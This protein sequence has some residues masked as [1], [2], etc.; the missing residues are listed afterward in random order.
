ML[1]TLPI[2]ADQT[3][4][5]P[6]PAV[7]VFQSMA[8]LTFAGLFVVP[9]AIFLFQRIAYLLRRKKRSRRLVENRVSSK[10]VVFVPCYREKSGI[11][12]R[13]VDSLVDSY[14]P[15]SSLQVFL[16]FD[17]ASEDNL[18]LDALEKLGMPLARR[19]GF[20]SSVDIVYKRVRVTVS[21][22]THGGKRCCQRN[23]FKLV[24]KVY[25]DYLRARG[26]IFALFV[27][28]D[29][30][31]DRH[32]IR[33]LVLEMELKSGTEGVCLA[34]TGVVTATAEKNSLITILQD[35]EY[36]HGQ[37]FERAIESACGA[38]TCLPGALT[39]IRFSTLN[40]LA[41]FYFAEKSAKCKDLF[42]YC[43]CH[44]GEDRWFTHLLMIAAPQRHQL[45]ICTSAFC[46]TESAQSFS[47][48]LKQRRRWFLGFLTNEVCI[49]SDRRLWR[50]YSLLCAIHLAQDTI[51]TTSL[52]FFVAM[53]SVL[54]GTRHYDPIITS[55]IALSFG[56]HWALM[57]S[58]AWNL[59][60]YK[61]LLFPV[62]F[63]VSQSH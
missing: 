6:K 4:N 7:I 35:L 29:C 33:N 32:C 34:M 21:R 18:Y 60:R 31:L 30:I 61:I 14:Y 17:E 63:L 36:I 55:L 62:L 16:S 44:L 20:P 12:L 59:R 41:N 56:L 43:R 42:N 40:K 25:G 5:F 11:L 47:A 13:T 9:W 1:V 37:L 19:A 45:G 46:K 27:D 3:R 52:V 49:L 15:S 10:V 8:I 53:F 48:L 28:S 23:T 22:F 2:S 38:V 26:N 24:S 50:K 57:A 39:M 54:T 58:F 51:T